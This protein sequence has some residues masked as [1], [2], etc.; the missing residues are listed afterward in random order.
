MEGRERYAVSMQIDTAI[1][2]LRDDDTG[3]VKHIVVDPCGMEKY[4]RV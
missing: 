3:G 4:I 2:W 1:V